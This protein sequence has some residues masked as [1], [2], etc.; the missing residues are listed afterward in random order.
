MLAVIAGLPDTVVGVE[1][2][3]EVTASDYQEVLEPAVE[4]TIERHGKARVLYV[5]GSEFTGFTM[6]AMWEDTKVG[7][8]RIRDWERCAI[9]SDMPLIVDGVKAVGWMFPSEIKLFSDAERE[10]ATAWICS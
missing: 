5:M 10:Q 7:L 8:G 6:G 3:G 2:V 9:V 4:A 1:A